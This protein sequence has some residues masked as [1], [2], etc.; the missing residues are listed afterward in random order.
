MKKLIS[1]LTDKKWKQPNKINLHSL[2]FIW[3]HRSLYGFIVL[4]MVSSG[5]HTHTRTLAIE[6]FV[7]S[8]G[9]HHI[10]IPSTIQGENKVRKQYFSEQ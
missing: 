7:V 10:R 5:C 8:V 4:L 9:D 3:F 2:T 1:S 6:H